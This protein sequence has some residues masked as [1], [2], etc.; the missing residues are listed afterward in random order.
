MIY[1][2]PEVNEWRQIQVYGTDFR[3][4]LKTIANIIDRFELWDWFKNESPPP[5]KGY[6]YWGH[7]NINKIS[8]NIP[9]NPHSGATFAF[10]LRIMQAIAKKGFNN[11]NTQHQ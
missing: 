4:E 2:T 5:N 11:W 1:S 10:A 8:Q 7:E 6:G 3:K 9:D